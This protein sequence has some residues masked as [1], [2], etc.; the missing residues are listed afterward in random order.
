MTECERIIKQGILP[1]SFFLPETICDFYVDE[2]RKKIWAV[3]LDLLLQFDR[4]CKKYGLKYF[5]I[6][7]SLLGA[8]RHGG[9]IPWDDDIDVGMLREDYDRFIELNDE[10]KNQY[11]LQTPYT[12][13]EYAYSYAKLRNT[14]TTCINKM[15]MYQNYK[16]G[17]FIDIFPYE[18]WDAENGEETY[19]QIHKLAIENS[20]YMRLKNPHLDKVNQER[21]NQW[22][23][24]NPLDVY[25]RI[26][27]LASKYKNVE[28]KYVSKV[29]FTFFYGQETYPKEYFDKIKLVPF[30]GFNIP[31]PVEYD[32][33]LTKFFGNYMEFPPIEKRDGGHGGA[34]FDADIAYKDYLKKNR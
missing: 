20:T 8:I 5:L 14:N 18:N 28:T 34:V 6:G 19:N 15:F 22:C 21:V 11:F 26:Q 9:F 7:G 29:V 10:F 23:G 4:V 17:I 27:T 13:P 1:E 16:M 32:K 30:E 12:D 25:E 3:E 31:I 33:I 2:K 24:M